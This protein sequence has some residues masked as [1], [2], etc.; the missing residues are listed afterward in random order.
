MRNRVVTWHNTSLNPASRTLILINH[1]VRSL[2]TPEEG[3]P[4]HLSP[5]VA[6][7]CLSFSPSTST[8][9]TWEK[10]LLSVAVLRG[11]SVNGRGTCSKVQWPQIETH[12]DRVSIAWKGRKKK[13]KGER[14][15]KRAGWFHVN[16]VIAYVTKQTLPLM[17]LCACDAFR[18]MVS[19]K[20]TVSRF[21]G[22]FA[23]GF[24]S[25]KRYTKFVR[26]FEKA[27]IIIKFFKVGSR[28]T[29]I[30]NIRWFW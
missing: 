21:G 16:P 22:S 5:R 4:D 18:L 6:A 9:L 17:K 11:P 25:S 29:S 28:E 13:E 2:D 20:G 24:A 15:L 3:I 26:L 30:D 1:R 19:S 10:R 23:V 7:S 27:S 14:G 12:V 8:K